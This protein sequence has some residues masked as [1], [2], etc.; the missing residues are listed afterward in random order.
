[1]KQFNLFFSS[2]GNLSKTLPQN[3]ISVSEVLSITRY[4]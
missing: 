1:M 4:Y 3:V 2:L